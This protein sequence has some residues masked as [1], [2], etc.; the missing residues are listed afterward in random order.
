MPPSARH[1]EEFRGVSFSY[2]I[3]ARVL[4]I[5]WDGLIILHICVRHYDCYAEAVYE[6]L[7]C[8]G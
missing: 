2:F 6:T 1:G 3:V 4:L 8:Y 7:E 5:L